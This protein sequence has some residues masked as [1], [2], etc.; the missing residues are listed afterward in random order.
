MQELTPRGAYWSYQNR[1]ILRYL[2]FGGQ[3]APS[4]LL[5]RRRTRWFASSEEQYVADFYV[6]LVQFSIASH[7]IIWYR[8]IIETHEVIVC[9]F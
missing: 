4:I 7:R 3:S 8:E 5:S 1:S 2:G 6:L 9:M